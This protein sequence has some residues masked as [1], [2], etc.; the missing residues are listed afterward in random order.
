MFLRDHHEGY[1]DWTNYEDNQRSIRNNG[2]GWERDESIGPARRGQGLLTGLLRCARCGRRLHVRYWGKSGT[3]ARYLC[4]GD[5]ESGGS[6]C[7]AFGGRRVDKRVTVE[8][9]GVLSPLGIEASTEAIRRLEGEDD[10]RRALLDKQLEQVEY[11]ARRAFEQYDRVD[12]RNRLVAAELEAR[13]NEKLHEVDAV[14]SA[15]AQLDDTHRP[16]NDA[17]RAE[18]RSL[19]THFADVWSSPSCPPEL[20]KED[21]THGHRS[22]RPPR[23]PESA[24]RPSGGSSRRASCHAT[25]SHRERHGR[26]AAWIWMCPPC[27]A[28]SI[29][30]AKPESSS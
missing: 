18:L 4:Q 10:G 21:R 17:E 30:Y 8:V 23:T 26:S 3:S 19:G 24:T 14:K 16:L 11:E 2:R 13:W 12:A 1:I 20:K 27:A 28:S 6:Y 29:T 5:Y 25:R 22:T 15:I 9:L 7:L